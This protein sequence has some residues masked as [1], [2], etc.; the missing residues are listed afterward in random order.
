MKKINICIFI[1][2]FVFLCYRAYVGYVYCSEFTIFESFSNDI[3]MHFQKYQYIDDY[4]EKKRY[5][6]LPDF[7]RLYAPKPVKSFYK[8]TKRDIKDS[9]I[10]ENYLKNIENKTKGEVIDG[11]FYEAPDDYIPF[12]FD[13]VNG[14]EE[15]NESEE[16]DEKKEDENFWV[17]DTIEVEGYYEELD[18]SYAG[19]PNLDEN[20]MPIGNNKFGKYLKKIYFYDLL[21]KNNEL[22]DLKKEAELFAKI[23]K[24]KPQN[25]DEYR[26]YLIPYIKNMI[27]SKKQNKPTSIEKIKDLP[28]PPEY[29]RSIK[30]IVYYWYL[31]SKLFEKNNEYE[32]ALLLSHGIFYIAKDYES[33]YSNSS[34]TDNKI[35]SILISYRACNSILTW[36]CRPKPNCIEISKRVA[37]DILDFVANEYP[38][39][40]I[41]EDELLRN[42]ENLINY[43]QGGYKV[44]S[45]IQKSKYYEEYINEC[46]KKA[47]DIVDKP[48]FEAIKLLDKY[49]KEADKHF[50]EFS[51][52]SHLYDSKIS[53]RII[54]IINVFIRPEY[55]LGNILY[56]FVS[57]NFDDYKKIISFNETKKAKMEMTAIA[58]AIN[59][60]YCEN[61][62]LPETMEE[63]N[64]WFGR[65]L[66]KNRFTNEIYKLD[67]NSNH[68]LYNLGVD[69]KADLS[70]ENT[71]DLYFDFIK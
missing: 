67:Y 44:F 54:V 3:F 43:S 51:N 27:G 50:E 59:A 70:D 10:R 38:L 64:K 36:A 61:N 22:Y 63:L 52:F 8:I 1:I 30:D 47:K 13:E 6:N 18:S 15:A 45:W 20:G 25:I 56:R 39:A 17:A 42:R 19:L 2:L 28:N 49:G 65:E 55:F 69:G 32:N 12:Y 14:N 46:Y 41:M 9:E 35:I 58:L 11:D 66:P 37:N 60:Y 71:D 31:L 34:S 5:E 26:N 48:I 4:E 33:N 57:K 53:S 21:P 62:K 29:R 24:L 7:I 23:D 16:T 68:I 40:I